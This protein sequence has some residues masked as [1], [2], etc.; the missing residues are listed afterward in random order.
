MS[1]H[2]QGIESANRRLL[3]RVGGAIPL[4]RSKIAELFVVMDD[5][6]TFEISDGCESGIYML[7]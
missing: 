3:Q 4:G 5:R 7:Q 1:V 6:G 2:L